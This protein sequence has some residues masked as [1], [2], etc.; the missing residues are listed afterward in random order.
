MSSQSCNEPEP[1]LH[2]E[3]VINEP[4]LRRLITYKNI[5]SFVWQGHF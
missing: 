3:E 5:N 2:C 4:I 1:S